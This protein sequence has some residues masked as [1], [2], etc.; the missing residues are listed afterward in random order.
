MIRPELARRLA[1]WRVAAVAAALVLAGAWIF[2]RGGWVF[3]PLGLAVVAVGLGW[4]AVE[5]NH[6]RLRGRADAQGLVEIEEGAVRYYA[7]RTLGGEVALRDLVEIRILRLGGR[8]HWR[9]RTRDG[10]ALLIPAD[11]AG[12]GALADGFAALPGADLGH[13]AA[14]LE[15]AGRD[16]PSVQTVW[17]A[18]K[19]RVGRA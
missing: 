10:Q 6:V 17:T 9:L 4:L 11:A 2:S 16:G 14:A 3:W 12:A 18:P 8:A 1:P 15:R 7:A 19:G 13:L 5:V